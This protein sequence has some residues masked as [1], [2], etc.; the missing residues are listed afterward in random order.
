MSDEFLKVRE[1]TKDEKYQLLADCI[2]NGEV[3]ME[4]LDEEFEKNQEFKKWYIEKYI[5]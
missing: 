1:Y 4:E 5:F 3:E 2:R